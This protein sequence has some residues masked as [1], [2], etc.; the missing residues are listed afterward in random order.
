MIKECA[1]QLVPVCMDIFN[2]SLVQ[3]I[4]PSCFK[5][6]TA[7]PLPKTPLHASTTFVPSRMEE[8]DTHVLML[9]LGLQFS[10]QHDHRQDL[11]CKLGPMGLNTSL[12][13]WLLD[14]LSDRNESVRGAEKQLPCHLPEHQY[15]PRLRSD[16]LAVHP[17]DTRLL[18]KVQ[19]QPSSSTGVPT[20]FQ[21][22]SYL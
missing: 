18:S 11:V 9:F 8:K 14:F 16:P 10:I 13:N 22:G 17:G 1:V 20:L 2:T 3:T 4:V 12:C 7:V 15:P 6:A 21:H 19:L 5:A